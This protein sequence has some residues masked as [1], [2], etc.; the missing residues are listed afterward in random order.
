MLFEPLERGRT[1]ML[2]RVS[3]FL[4]WSNVFVGVRVSTEDR[5]VYVCPLPCCTL[6]INWGRKYWKKKGSL[7]KR[8]CNHVSVLRCVDHT[9]NKK[10]WIIYT[11]GTAYT[12][13]EQSPKFPSA[14]AAMAY[15]DAQMPMEDD[16]PY[17]GA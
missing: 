7:W 15:A 6:Q 12:E 13:D 14:W 1:P 4:A 11:N 16:L 8:S 5:A 3:F 17:D 2:L 10:S 9:N